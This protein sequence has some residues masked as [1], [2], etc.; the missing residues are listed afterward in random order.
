MTDGVL[1]INKHSGISSFD[2]V[3]GVRSI[4]GV[5]KVGHCGTLDPLATG[6][7]VV[8]LG[9][10]TKLA[11][12]I[13][14]SFKVYEADVL[15][16]TVTNTLDRY[17]VVMER[18]DTSAVS[19]EAVKSCLRRFTGEMLQ[20]VPEFSAAKLDG[21]PLYFYARRSEQVPPRRKR[22]TIE[23]LQLT[24]FEHPHV[25]IRI[26]CSRGTYVRAIASDIGDCLGCGA[27]LFS[28]RRTQVGRFVLRRAITLGQLTAR[29][30]M[31]LADQ[32]IVDPA[33]AIDFPRI[34]VA[35]DRVDAVRSGV[36]LLAHDVRAID[37]FV[38]GEFLS[39]IDDDG[40]LL[41]IGTALI[42]SES[43]RNSEQQCGIIR[44]SR[45]M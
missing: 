42:D 22:I 1:L 14:N 30:R 12:H 9:K 26:K 25:R 20:T 18:T 21:K 41:A 44:Y 33:Q 11:S 37:E 27:S 16:G 2:V 39:L 7:V 31:N 17:G 15:L 29:V 24:A 10:A 4:L 28:L 13:S 3:A 34:F 36:Q 38:A 19:S 6:L 8:C 43:L 32:V 5:R 23:D 35:N 40:R 45:V